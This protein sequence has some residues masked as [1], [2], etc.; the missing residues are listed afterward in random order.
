MW[1]RGGWEEKAAGLE[2]GMEDGTC[3]LPLGPRVPDAFWL[4]SLAERASSSI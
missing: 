2:W 1:W 4:A 3:C